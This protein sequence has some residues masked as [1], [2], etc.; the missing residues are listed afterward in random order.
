MLSTAWQRM[1]TKTS[2]PNCQAALSNY[3]RKLNGGS[4]R[5]SKRYLWLPKPN[6]TSDVLRLPL[7]VSELMKAGRVQ[8][9]SQRFGLWMTQQGILAALNEIFDCEIQGHR[10]RAAQLI[11][12]SEALQLGQMNEI[13]ITVR[14]SQATNKSPWTTSSGS[15]R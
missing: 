11:I 15:S 3:T 2:R 7:K 5:R 6:V 8:D 10:P 12:F 14:T 1:A 9:A 13:D 4:V